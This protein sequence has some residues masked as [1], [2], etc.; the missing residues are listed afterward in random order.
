MKK[1]FANIRKKE[2][3]PE[4]LQPAFVLNFNP[5][6]VISVEVTCDYIELKSGITSRGKRIQS[7]EN[8]VL[9]FEPFVIKFQGY[10]LYV[11]FSDSGL[12][13]TSGAVT[14]EPSPGEMTIGYSGGRPDFRS[15]Y[16]SWEFII[17]D[18]TAGKAYRFDCGRVDRLRISLNSQ[19]KIVL[20]R[21][22]I[23]LDRGECLYGCPTADEVAG[24]VP[25]CML[26]QFEGFDIVDL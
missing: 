11:G 2:R 14:S 16:G 1:W 19:G 18:E 9:V 4:L 26:N 12:E 21:K 20:S 3:E 7:D 25:A 23:E 13:E 17:R 8:S 5:R 15:G 6:H 24:I 22:H 10:K